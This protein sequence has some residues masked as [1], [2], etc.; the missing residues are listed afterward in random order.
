LLDGEP[1]PVEA[2]LAFQ[3]N[4]VGGDAQVELL[5]GGID[6]DG[7]KSCAFCFQGE[8]IIFRDLCCA[9]LR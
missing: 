9:P 7:V 3:F 8:E 6:I 4:G 1:L 2:G 5:D